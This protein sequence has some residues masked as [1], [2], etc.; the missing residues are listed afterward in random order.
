MNYFSIINCAYLQNVENPDR[1]KTAR[2]VYVLADELI[3]G[4]GKDLVDCL[5]RQMKKDLRTYTANVQNAIM[6]QALTMTIESFLGRAVH[7]KMPEKELRKSGVDMSL[8]CTDFDPRSHSDDEVFEYGIKSCMQLFSEEYANILQKYKHFCA[9]SYPER[10]KE[11]DTLMAKVFEV[12]GLA[13]RP[14]AHHNDG[15]NNRGDNPNQRG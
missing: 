2:A 1:V 8:R 11:F 3:G 15:N 12:N 6:F 4:Y 7:R 5:P 13:P 14:I 9:L 10:A